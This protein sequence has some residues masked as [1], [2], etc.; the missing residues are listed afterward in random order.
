MARGRLRP[1][2]RVGEPFQMVSYERL[3]RSLITF[4]GSVDAISQDWYGRGTG[5]TW[6]RAGVDPALVALQ[7]DGNHAA[8]PDTG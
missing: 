5:T 6:G 8:K 2:P 4:N 7:L 3:P 1:R